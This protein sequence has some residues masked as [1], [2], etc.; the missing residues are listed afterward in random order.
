MAVATST[1]IAPR[2]ITTLGYSWGGRRSFK[3]REVDSEPLAL[4]EIDGICFVNQGRWPFARAAASSI[5]PFDSKT[6]SNCRLYPA[7]SL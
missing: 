3:E 6:D 7:Y 2:S 4:R 1:A 5:I